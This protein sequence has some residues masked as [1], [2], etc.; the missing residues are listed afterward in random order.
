MFILWFESIWVQRLLEEEEEE[1]EEEEDEEEQEER[2]KEP[3]QP[4]GAASLLVKPS[5]AGKVILSM[6]GH[7]PFSKMP[8]YHDSV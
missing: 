3:A 4:A 5:E 7:L 6:T 1:E 2:N 8:I